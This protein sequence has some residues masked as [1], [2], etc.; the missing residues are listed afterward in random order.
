MIEAAA[1]LFRKTVSIGWDQQLGG[2]FYTLD[3]SDHP[4]QADRYWWPLAEGVGAAAALG[5]VER[6]PDLRTMVPAHLELPRRPCDR[7][8]AWLAPE[9]DSALNPVSRVFEGRPD[10]YHAVQACSSRCF[11][12]TAASPGRSS[13]TASSFSGL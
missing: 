11:P 4:D 12:P 7:Q 1:G 13:A 5:S 10:I 6:R 8:D 9:L 2:F 3:W